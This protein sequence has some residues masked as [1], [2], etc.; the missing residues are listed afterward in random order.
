[1]R[2]FISIVLLVLVGKLGLFGAQ[3]AWT[4]LANA[5][6]QSSK[7]LLGVHEFNIAAQPAH[8]LPDRVGLL[9]QIGAKVVRLPI[10]WHLFEGNGKG[11]TAQWFW[12]ELDAEVAAAQRAGVKLII[13]VGYSPCWASS[14]PNKRCND[15]N[16]FDY[17]QYPPINYNDYG[18]AMARLAGRYRGRV[19]AWELWNEPNLVGNW[20]AV[21]PRPAAM[22]DSYNLFSDLLGARQYTLLV[23]DSYRKIKNADPQAVVLAGSIA[24]GDVAYVNEMYKSGIK[25]YFDALSMHPYTAVYPVAPGD[26][27]YGKSYGPDECFPNTKESKFWCFKVGVENLRKAMLAKGD[28]KPIWFSEFGFSSTTVWNGSGSNGQAEHLRKAVALINN[29]NFV[30]VACLY[31]LV[32]R[33]AN[34]ERETRFGLFDTNLNIKPAGEAYK[35]LIAAVKP[36]PISPQG[37]ITTNT[38]TFVWQAVPGATSYKLW[39]NEYGI[40]NVPGKIN[41]DFTPA[42]ANC[43]SD[44]TC[45]V[46]PGVRFA[47]ASAEWWA[48]AYFNNG[49]SKLSDSMTFI[50][51][52]P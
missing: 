44:A 47:P 50:V 39:V 49:T 13:E 37:E 8:N 42:Q 18:D 38:P 20:K 19:Y 43:A 28:N 26:P 27:K 16:Y 40:P 3:L 5:Q 36:I 15:P 48:S 22:N 9:Q 31:Q 51:K 1:M 46:S 32:D 41:R 29:W 6:Q 34:D 23:K 10:S 2:K 7:K 4:Q 45:T 12:D 17:L 35:Q 33:A 11:Q 52:T 14:A 21:N 25:G 30:P 24:G